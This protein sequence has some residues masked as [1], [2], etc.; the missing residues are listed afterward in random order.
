LSSTTAGNN[1]TSIVSSILAESD[2]SLTAAAYSYSSL[3]TKSDKKSNNDQP[4]ARYYRYQKMAEFTATED[5][6]YNFSMRMKIN[7]PTWAWRA[8]LTNNDGLVESFFH[9]CLR[10]S[11]SDS[12]MVTSC[13]MSDG[14]TTNTWSESQYQT[15][16]VS[17][18][19]IKKGDVIRVWMTPSYTGGTRPLN[20][21]LDATL[22]STEL[23]CQ[24]DLQP[25]QELPHGER[26]LKREPP[27][28]T[29]AVRQATNAS[30][31]GSWS[32]LLQRCHSRSPSL[33]SCADKAGKRDSRGLPPQA[34]E[35]NHHPCY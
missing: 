9:F 10:C 1:N 2:A 7:S 32:E 19:N 25:R 14:Y 28:V 31:L 33:Q 13:S 4:D 3:V 35:G 8:I 5:G 17:A 16:K 6:S 20:A 11:Q 27:S 22:Y 21:P 26:A 24:Q 18:K 34:L 29:S 12:G 15:H 30:T 23:C